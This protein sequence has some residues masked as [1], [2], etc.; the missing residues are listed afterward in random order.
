MIPFYG[1][2]YLATG[3]KP[4]LRKNPL[5]V[6]RYYLFSIS[7]LGFFS[8]IPFLESRPRDDDGII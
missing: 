2:D 1:E 3:L 4:N 7:H 5:S 8:S 6:I